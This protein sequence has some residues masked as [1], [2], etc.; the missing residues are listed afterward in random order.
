MKKEKLIEKLNAAKKEDRLKALQKLKNM[1]DDGMIERP[2]TGTD[3]NN[4]IH[5]IYSFSPYSPAKAVWMAYNAGLQTAGIMDHDSLSGAEEFIEAGKIIGLKTTVG[6][7]CRASMTGT[8]MEG[9]KLNNPDQANIAYMAL[10]GVPHQN[11]SQV[12]EFFKPYVAYR[13]IRNE[14]MVDRINGLFNR[15]GI[16]LS[17]EDDIVPI[18]QFKNGGS[19]T[20]RHVLFALGKKIIDKCGRGPETVLF[21][22]NEFGMKFSKKV[23]GFLME[24]DPFFEYDLLGALKSDLISKIYIDATDECAPVSKM[25][26]FGKEIGAVSAYAYLGD[27]GDSVTG[28]KKAQKFEDD[29]IEEL[30][31]TLDKLGFNAVT[32]MPSRNTRDQLVRVR[33]LCDEHGLFQ[34]SGEDINSPRQKFICEAQRDPEFSNLRDATFALIGHEKEASKDSSLSMF[35]DE[36]IKKMP[37]LSERIEYFKKKA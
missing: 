22:E 9:R 30:F 5:T 27:V 25:I 32:Y 12:K 2:Q 8:A 3:V 18:S 17:F 11:I 4:H 7:E 28:D 23:R 15:F 14:K 1:I 33:K 31:D 21:L 19:I 20:E 29:Y 24:D 6:V 34:I 10:H 36:T 26:S 13:N 35:S 16:K 37:T